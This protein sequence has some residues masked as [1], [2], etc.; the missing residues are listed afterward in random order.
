MTLVDK[1]GTGNA[2]SNISDDT[3]GMDVSHAD[4]NTPNWWQNT[5]NWSSGGAWNFTSIWVWDNA[6]KL[7]KLRNVGGQ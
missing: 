6:A 1:D 2:T 5:G 3:H 7:P 4:Y